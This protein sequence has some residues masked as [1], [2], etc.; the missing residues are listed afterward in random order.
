MVQWELC[1]RGIGTLNSYRVWVLFMNSPFTERLRIQERMQI[2]QWEDASSD[3]CNK[4][5]HTVTILCLHTSGT[6]GAV[7]VKADCNCEYGK[8]NVLRT[9]GRA[10]CFRGV[11]NLNA[12][13]A[14]TACNHVATTSDNELETVWMVIVNRSTIIVSRPI[15]LSLCTHLTMVYL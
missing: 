10:S 8:Y 11:C 9:I 5:V 13:V 4:R 6:P 14:D 1:D 7:N 15:L 12:W 3:Y 2:V